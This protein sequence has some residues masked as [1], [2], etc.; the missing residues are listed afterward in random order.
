MGANRKH[1]IPADDIPQMAEETPR[2][3]TALL[4]HV[5]LLCPKC[6]KLLC[7]LIEAV[8]EHAMATSEM[9]ACASAGGHSFAFRVE[10]E[11]ARG[12]RQVV[13]ATWAEYERHRQHH[14]HS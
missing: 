1:R 3:S 13:L 9:I 6:V 14:F 12:R 2:W 8:D 7:Q 5:E 11:A 4:G 10:L